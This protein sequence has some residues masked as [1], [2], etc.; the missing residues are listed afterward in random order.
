MHTQSAA[1]LVI[2]NGIFRRKSQFSENLNGVIYYADAENKSIEIDN[3][4]LLNDN[5]IPCWP[6]PA[7]LLNMTDRHEVMRRCIDN[8]IVSHK[9]I[10]I[11]YDQIDAISV[12]PAVIKTGHSHRGIGKFLVNSK[13]EIEPWAGIATVE[14]FFKGDS[15]R[16]LI[17]G[18][19]E[20]GIKIT[21]SNSWIA[22]S[23]GAE[24][25]RFTPSKELIE[26][27]RKATDLFGIDAAGVDYIL[28]GNDFHF[29]EINQFPGL[30][31]DDE[32]AEYAKDFLGKKM[33]Y[34][35]SLN[36]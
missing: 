15:V 28:S 3:L 13:N 26:H 22:N 36:V 31:V 12:Y 2:D 17:L 11:T 6:N 32:I 23:P 27:A 34:V 20:F 10:Q 33:A 9:V 19:K 16:I 25:S 4:T 8:N 14:P 30:D 29:L 35:E 24:S 18:E 7:A 5:S 21:N 1:R